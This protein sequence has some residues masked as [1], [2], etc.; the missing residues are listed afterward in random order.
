MVLAWQLNQ[1]ESELIAFLNQH[2]VSVRLVGRILR[3]WPEKALAKIQENPYRLLIIVPW[4]A[5]DRLA[6]AIGIGETDDRR[7]IAA[8]EAGV[9]KFLDVNRD[10]KS[11]SSPLKHSIRNL[12]H[13]SDEELVRLALERAVAEGALGMKQAVTRHL[14]VE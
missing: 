14:V 10:T 1:Q 13:T 2:N 3:Y 4:I 11:E 9:Y 12:L 8:A 5:V 7:L 6:R